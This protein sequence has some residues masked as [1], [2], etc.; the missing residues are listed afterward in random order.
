MDIETIKAHALA[1]KE[2]AVSLALQGQ[3]LSV[4]D[5]IQAER[6]RVCKTDEER[7]AWDEAFL[8]K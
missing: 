8:A 5:V 4:Y 6:E 3:H 7:A 2:K 1:A